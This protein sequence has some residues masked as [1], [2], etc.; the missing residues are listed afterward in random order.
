MNAIE[1]IVVCAVEAENLERIFWYKRDDEM[2]HQ[3]SHKVFDINNKLFSENIHKTFL[4][5][6]MV[7]LLK[8]SCIIARIVYFFLVRITRVF[9]SENYETFDPFWESKAISWPLIFFNNKIMCPFFLSPNRH[10]SLCWPAF[11][12]WSLLVH[13]IVNMVDHTMEALI[14]EAP[15]TVARI[16]ETNTM[17]IQAMANKTMAAIITTMAITIIMVELTESNPRKQLNSCENNEQ[18]HAPI[19]IAK[20]IVK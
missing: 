10:Y 1:R 3:V 12:Y 2:H 13:S 15:I 5:S 7:K 18:I 9:N 16:M 20:F 17:D 14:M 11:W 19:R 6:K 4:V 8:V